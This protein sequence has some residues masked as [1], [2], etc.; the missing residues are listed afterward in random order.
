MSGWGAEGEPLDS[1]GAIALEELAPIVLGCAWIAGT[2]G[3]SERTSRLTITTLFSSHL[4]GFLARDTTMPPR[5]LG[6]ISTFRRVFAVQSCKEPKDCQE[7]VLFSSCSS[8]STAERMAYSSHGALE[9]L[10]RCTTN[11]T[12][13]TTITASKTAKRMYPV[14]PDRPMKVVGPGADETVMVAT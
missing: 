14:S 13:T 5:P 7:W 10:R 12:A 1:V 8:M 9:A 6:A 3:E 4:S 11:A 2:K